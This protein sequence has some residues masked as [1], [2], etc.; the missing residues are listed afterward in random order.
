MLTHVPPGSA[1]DTAEVAPMAEPPDDGTA[2]FGSMRRRLFGIAY[3]IVGRWAE[4]EDVVQ[5][6][7]LRWQAYDRTAVLNPT[8]FLVATTTRLAINATQTAR[9]RHDSYVGDWAHEPDDS[10]LDP[11]AS[12]VRSDELEGAILRLHERLSA[13]ERAAY[14]LREAFGYSYA[15]IADL[16]E[17]TEVNARQLVSRAGKNL[18]G[19][20]SKTVRPAEQLRLVA[21][22]VVAAR[23]GELTALEQLLTRGRDQPA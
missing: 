17:V 12:A 3:R 14:L 15:K 7:W 23:A 21:A 16:L 22:F 2:V 8:A 13:N 18:A 9:A 4:A 10:G 20:R 19:H 11:S 6:V 1:A 5:D